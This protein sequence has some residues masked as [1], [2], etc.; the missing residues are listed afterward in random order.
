VLGHKR[1]ILFV[2]ALEEGHVEVA[3][4]H[5]EL[6][7]GARPERVASGDLETKEGKER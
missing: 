3:R 6:L 7:H 4:V 1:R 5:S 2:A